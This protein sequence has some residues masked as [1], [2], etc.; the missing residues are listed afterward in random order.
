MEAITY[1]KN[2][3]V[4][5]K[6]LRFLLSAVKKL[7]PAQAVDYLYYSP[8]KAGRVLYKVLQSAIANGKST[9]KTD[10]SLLQFKLLT[11]E[12]GQ[13]MKRYRPG[14]RGTAKPIRHE[15]SHVKV[16]LQSTAPT[17]K[18]E[19]KEKEKTVKAELPAKK[20]SPKK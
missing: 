19:I 16:I 7:K 2:L 11:V 8:Q 1:F 14:G 15:Y 9:L 5:P 18:L 17:V 4:S 20:V 3:K 6:K 13:R 10:A 12:E